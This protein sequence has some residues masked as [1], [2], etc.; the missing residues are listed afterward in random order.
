MAGG[1]TR[2]RIGACQT[3]RLAPGPEGPAATNVTSMPNL[4]NS[5]VV[6]S[7]VT[8]SSFHGVRGETQAR[9]NLDRLGTGLLVMRRIEPGDITNSIYR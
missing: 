5:R 9:R 2:R 3:N 1:R 4:R 6:S 8:E 7:H